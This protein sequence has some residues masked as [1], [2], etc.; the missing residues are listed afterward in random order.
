MATEG[1]SQKL[2][3]VAGADLRTGAQYKA[4]AVG[5]TIAAASTAAI[6]ILQNKPNTGEHASLAWHGH[7]KAYTGGAVTAGARVKVTTSGYIVVVASGDGAVGKAITAAASG[8]L[9]EIIADFAG[10]ATTY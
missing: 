10:A 2:S 6:G 1:M 7:M 9:C 5:G 8:A 4:I 3:I